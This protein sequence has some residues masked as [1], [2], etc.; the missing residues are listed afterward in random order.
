MTP[1][2][3]PWSA[4]WPPLASR[5]RRRGSAVTPRVARGKRANRR[6]VGSKFENRHGGPARNC[7]RDAVIGVPRAVLPR[8]VL[9]IFPPDDRV[10]LFVASMCMA[11][12]DVEDAKAE[13]EA[14]NPPNPD[15]PDVAHRRRFSYRVRLLN[16][17]LYEGIVALKAW[18]QSE[19]EIRNLLDALENDAKR[20]L[21][22]VCGLE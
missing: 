17:H 13:A 20:A 9:T 16:G 3:R 1:T 2:S 21:K 4:T 7:G 8:N 15:H 14:A 11:C 10:S 19:A 6:S 18:R 22:L 12:N 5:P